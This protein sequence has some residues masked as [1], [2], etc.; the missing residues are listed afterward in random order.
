MN[1]IKNT[2]RCSYRFAGATFIVSLCLFFLSVLPSYGRQ[3]SLELP[4][5][6]D[7]GLRFTSLPFPKSET[8]I[9]GE[10]FTLTGKG[11]KAVVKFHLPDSMIVING[12]K[13]KDIELKG[14]FRQRVTL[15]VKVTKP[16]DHSTIKM[17]VRADYPV[18]AI[19][20]KITDSNASQIVKTRQTNL[21]RSLLGRKIVSIQKNIFVSDKEVST[22]NSILWNNYVTPFR[23]NSLKGMFA[24]RDFV[25]GE[26]VS[27]VRNRLRK[28]EH[29][30]RLLNSGK[31]MDAFSK[32]SFK[33]KRLK[34]IAAYGE[35]LYVLSC[36]YCQKS[37]SSVTVLKE[38]LRK[39]KS[40]NQISTETVVAIANLLALSLVKSSGAKAG[41]GGV[42]SA[43]RVWSKLAENSSTGSLNVY[44]LYNTG[45]ALRIL[46]KKKEAIEFFRAALLERPGLLV[47]SDR[48]RLF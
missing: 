25:S 39:A 12:N 40:Y 18:V 48:L 20:K 21:A 24:A 23:G 41:N 37:P 38:N 42:K 28:F 26:S 33:Q 29:F 7:L 4:V 2:I 1:S 45:E 22:E 14:G 8:T 10:I 16:F 47:S 36:F 46:G 31:N 13:E 27:D 34:K 11:G 5:W 15:K 17:S 9:V 6:L 30:E 32:G 3:P 35:D 44:M 43:I 19:V